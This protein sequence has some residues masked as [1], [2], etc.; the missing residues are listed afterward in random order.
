M[1]KSR[2]LVSYLTTARGRE[3]L[4]PVVATWL[5]LVVVGCKREVPPKEP[6][7]GAIEVLPDP[8][9][10]KGITVISI[11]PGRRVRVVFGGEERRLYPTPPLRDTVIL[12]PERLHMPTPE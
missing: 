9:P 11:P 12:V 3:I 10:C 7:P 1:L 8:E 6:D 5:L 2:S 4:L